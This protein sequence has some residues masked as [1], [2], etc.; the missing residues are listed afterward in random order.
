M[1]ALWG[2]AYLL[3]QLEVPNQ[4]DMEKEIAV[5]NA[6]TRKRYLEQGRKHAYSI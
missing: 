1:Q 2:V 3:G 4:D 5:W 6:W